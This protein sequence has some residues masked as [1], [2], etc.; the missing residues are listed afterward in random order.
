MA[1]KNDLELEKDKKY[2]IKE[3]MKVVHEDNPSLVMRV[4]KI[5]RQSKVIYLND[6]PINKVFVLGVR[7]RWFNDKNELETAVFN[8]RELKK[9]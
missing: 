9:A 6:K 3:N 4:E 1:K 7:C 8:T 2:W 5:L